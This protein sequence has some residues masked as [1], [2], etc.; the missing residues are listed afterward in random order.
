MSALINH[1]PGMLQCRGSMSNR[2]G[3]DSTGKINY[4]FNQ[5]G[6]R[7]NVD[8]DFI[9]DYAFFGCSIVFGIGV[10]LENIFSSYFDNSQNYGIAGGYDN[11]DV[12][13][14]I[15]KFLKSDLYSPHI[16]IAVVWTDRNNENLDT[17]YRKLKDYDIKHFFCGEKLPYDNC[18]AMLG[19]LDND[20]SMTH[21]G[22]KTHR[23]FYKL[24][25]AL[26]N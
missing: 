19:N 10:P 1:V 2:F 4:K 13:I 11:N 16:K 6:F 23:F 17:Y 14:I 12:Y 5:Q 7:S 22:S 24:L 15:D 3:K 20:V 25:Q 26:F 21:M 18:Y 9:P 8:F